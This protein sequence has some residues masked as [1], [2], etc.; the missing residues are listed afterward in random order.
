MY[1]FIIFVIIILFL[2][3]LFGRRIMRSLVD[4]YLDSWR[5]AIPKSDYFPVINKLIVNQKYFIH[6]KIAASSYFIP[7][8]YET[9]DTIPPEALVLMKY[10]QTRVHSRIRNVR[11]APYN[12][13]SFAPAALKSPSQSGQKPLYFIH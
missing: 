13:S 7:L 2:A 3:L 8:E 6:I 11:L 10:S 12:P 5:F 9:W 1:L 4:A